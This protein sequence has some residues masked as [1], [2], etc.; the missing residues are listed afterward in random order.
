MF[1]GAFIHA[2]CVFFQPVDA[3]FSVCNV[4]SAF[5]IGASLPVADALKAE[6]GSTYV[7]VFADQR[8]QI[9]VNQPGM[10][11]NDKDV[12]TFVAVGLQLLDV[13]RN[14]GTGGARAEDA[15]GFVNDEDCAGGCPLVPCCHVFAFGNFHRRDFQFRDAVNEERA[16]FEIVARH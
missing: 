3:V 1:F 2:E 13:V 12:D 15:L 4:V 11:G 9:D 5:G 6:H 10:L 14:F 7:A 8:A 16:V